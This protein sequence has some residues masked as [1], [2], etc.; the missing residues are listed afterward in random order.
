M[1]TRARASVIRAKVWE[2]AHGL[3]EMTSRRSN[4][5]T[6][7]PC[8]VSSLARLTAWSSNLPKRLT[9]QPRRTSAQYVY[10]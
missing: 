5:T 2:N 7:R 8:A 1:H 6:R 3:K 4:F 10:A 9:P